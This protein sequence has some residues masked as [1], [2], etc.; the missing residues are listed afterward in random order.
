MLLTLF[1]LEVSKANK[2]D[3][4]FLCQEKVIGRANSKLQNS[5]VAIVG[6]GGT[7]CNSALL[8]A[9]LGVKKVK[10]IDPD[11]VELFNLPRQP[12][13][14]EKDV[15]R[16][17]VKV[18][19]EKLADYGTKFTACQELLDEKNASKLLKGVDVVLDCTDNYAA[20][21]AING[22]CF[23]N[24]TPWIYSA[25]IK[26]NAM[27]SVFI[28]GK[29]P[30]FNC[31]AP[32]QPAKEI[33]CAEEGVI[34]TSTAF[35]AVLQVQELV[36]LLKNDAK[37]AGKVFFVNLSTFSFEFFPLSFSCKLCKKIFSK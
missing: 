2:M 12:L 25:A 36:N 22:F 30:C 16:S 10:L 11:V 26:D 17:K 3:S 15:G 7:G 20:R 1:K 29:T 37:C 23:K 8:L 18:A 19:V 33:S 4:K 14:A 31:F 27:I 24:K 5:S 34:A 32:R 6:I 9:Q 35:A 28:P 21:K 13:F